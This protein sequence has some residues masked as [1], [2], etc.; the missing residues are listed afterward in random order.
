[1]TVDLVVKNGILVLPTGLCQ[2]GVAVEGERILSLTKDQLLPNAERVIDARG[3]FILPGIIDPHTHLGTKYPLDQNLATETQGAVAG[4]VCTIGDMLGSPGCFLPHEPFPKCDEDVKSWHEAFPSFKRIGEANS[5]VDFF[6]NPQVQSDIEIKE[7]PEYARDY[8]ITSVKFYCHMKRADLTDV[9][10]KWK[11]RIGLPCEYDDGL[12]FLA[13]KNA[14]AMGPPAMVMVHCENSEITSR[15]TKKLQEEGRTDPSAWQERSSGLPEAEHVRRYSYLAK[16]T[17]ARLYVVHLSSQLG[18]TECRNAIRE[19]TDLVVETCPQYLVKTKDDPEGSLLKVNPPIQRRE[20]NLAL[21]EGIKEGTVTCIGTDHVV[22]TLKDKMAHDNIRGEGASTSN[23]WEVGSGM[24]GLNTLLPVMWT[25]GVEKKRITV[26]KLVEICSTNV[27]RAF[28]LFPKKGVL[29]VGSDADLVIVNPSVRR[30]IT[31]DKLHTISDFTIYNGM[32]ATGWP[33]Y[34]IL[35]G[36]VVYENDQIV[37]E[38]GYGKYQ[39]RPLKPPSQPSN[40]P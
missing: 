40:E 15:L 37:G 25:E 9:H 5:Y 17:A 1:M 23:I 31:P 36:Q 33:E 39:P 14:A 10:P 20:D 13:M 35:R 16:M 2:G 3:S 26:Q 4:G 34:T 22:N 24:T 38:K 12:I 6:V 7:M 27:A 30:K 21:W 8:G 29:A 28:G 32:E 19:G 11:S 18:L